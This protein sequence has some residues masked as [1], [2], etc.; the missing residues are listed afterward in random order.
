MIKK[1]CPT[2]CGTR[3]RVGP[4]TL[5]RVRSPLRRVV[6]PYVGPYARTKGVCAAGGLFI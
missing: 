1:K 2:G 6:G 5:S 4:Y 3:G